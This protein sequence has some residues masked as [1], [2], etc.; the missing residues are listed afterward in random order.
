MNERVKALHWPDL[1]LHQAYRLP[2][3]EA[4]VPPIPPQR[5]LVSSGGRFN[6]F[7]RPDTFYE[8]MMMEPSNIL[9][10]STIFR[11]QCNGGNK[12][13]P[14]TAL[15]WDYER[16]LDEDRDMLTDR[17]ERVAGTNPRER[18]TDGDRSPG[19]S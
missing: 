15:S 12:E 3:E 16:D 19:R 10:G 13:I 17:A 4:T 7:L 5:I 2:R 8:A 1:C 9:V 14:L 18:D 11:S 6:A